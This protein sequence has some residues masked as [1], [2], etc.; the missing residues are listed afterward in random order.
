MSCLRYRGIVA[1]L[2][3]GAVQLAFTTSV[4]AAVECTASRMTPERA[5]SPETAAINA[6]NNAIGAE[7]AELAEKLNQLQEIDDASRLNQCTQARLLAR[8]GRTQEIGE[9]CVQACPPPIKGE[10]EV[11]KKNAVVPPIAVVSPITDRPIEKITETEKRPETEKLPET[12]KLPEIRKPPVVVVPPS[13]KRFA[14]VAGAD[15]APIAPAGAAARVGGSILIGERF[16]ADAGGLFAS[17]SGGGFLSFLYGFGGKDVQLGPELGA[18]VL[19]PYGEPHRNLTASPTAAIGL[20]FGGKFLYPASGPLA[21][22]LAAGGA[23]FP[24]KP[25]EFASAVFL[26]NAGLRWSIL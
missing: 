1:A 18:S 21:V 19:F 10:L 7:Q 23:A 15:Y 9:S 3:W 20:H 25:D 14:V 11:A 12:K 5:D 2:S 8:L 26:L 16:Y 24:V 4:N 22:S 6:A 17:R 13:P